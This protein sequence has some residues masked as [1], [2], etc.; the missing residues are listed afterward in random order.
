MT[1]PTFTPHPLLKKGYVQTVVAAVLPHIG[2][3]ER[4]QVEWVRLSDG[5]ELRLDIDAP[6]GGLSKQPLVLLLHG[7]GGSGDDSLIV[8]QAQKFKALGYVA[9]RFHHR[10]CGDGAEQKV[11]GLYHAGRLSDLVDVLDYLN[12]K[13]PDRP[14]LII[15]YSLSG[16]MILRLLGDSAYDG[17]NNIVAALAICPPIVLETASLA[18][19]AWRNSPID[20]FMTARFVKKARRIEAKKPISLRREL[21]TVFRAR[22]LDEVYTSRV[23]G[24]NGRLAYYK[25]CSAKD[26]LSAIEVPVSILCTEDDP[27]IPVAMFKTGIP[28]NVDLRIEGQG[29][30]VAFIDRNF[31]EFGDHRWLDTYVIDWVMS[32]S[33]F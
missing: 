6:F 31:T 26:Y 28:Q 20:Y 21:P 24:F 13:W 19:S 27:I 10:G 22:E 1:T 12:A 7:T 2:R 4:S 23:A 14:C 8:R 16:N 29:G 18:L 5:D 11:R 33:S 30:H 3:V 15:G 17:K 25:A 9:I 32:K